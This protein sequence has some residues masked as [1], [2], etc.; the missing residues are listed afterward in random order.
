MAQN[1]T[2]KISLATATIIGMNAMIGAGIFAAPAAIATYAGPAGIVACILVVISVWFM[3]NSMARLAYLFPQEG[4]FYLYTKQWSGHL[5][6]MIAVSAYFIGL[7]IAMGLLCHMGGYYLQVF[8]PYV[9]SYALGLFILCA[10]VALNLYGV[11]CSQ[12]GQQIL[13]CCTVFPLLATTIACFSKADWHN[14]IPFA[15][16]GYG[17]ILKA[18]RVVIFSFFGFEC[19]SSLYTIVQDPIKNVPRALTYSIFIVGVIYTLFIASIILATPATFF[20]DQNVRASEILAYLFPGNMLIL[21]L[22][23][24]SILSAILGTIHSMIWACSSLLTTIMHRVRNKS[25]AAF[26]QAGKF[27]DYHA[28]LFVGFWILV[29]Y[30][31]FENINLFFYFTAIFIVCSFV[32]SMITLLTIPSEWK[33]HQNIKTM[34][35][36]ITATAIFLFAIEGV[37]CELL[38]LTHHGC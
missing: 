18:T 27:K 7:L 16:Y 32:M 28:V 3:A 4:S 2:N 21:R 5:G 17:N 24:I 30:L 31:T 35:G 8:F 6:G 9:S 22:V 10:F 25:V 33:N 13:I 34:F 19:A 11:S 1:D 29:S 23:D 15:P 38:N 36:I 37:V 14:L 12:L 26:V 20:V